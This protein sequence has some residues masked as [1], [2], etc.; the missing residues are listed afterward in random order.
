M[1]D[2]IAPLSQLLSEIPPPPRVPREPT[3]AEVDAHYARIAAR[4][5]ELDAVKA[6]MAVKHAA[7]TVRPPR[8]SK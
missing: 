8:K 6:A 5:A 4:Q 7:R 2:S 3:L 1:F